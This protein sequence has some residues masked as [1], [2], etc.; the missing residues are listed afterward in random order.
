[1]DMA[2]STSCASFDPGMVR[3]APFPTRSTDSREI[4]S[5]EGFWPTAKA[6]PPLP[7]ATDATAPPALSFRRGLLIGMTG[8]RREM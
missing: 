3:M 8:D 5:A 6:A 2:L 7:L 4:A 1:M